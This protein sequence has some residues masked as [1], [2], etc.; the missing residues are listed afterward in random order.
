MRYCCFLIVP[1]LCAH[2]HPGEGRFIDSKPSGRDDYGPENEV[3]LN[4]FTTL[5]AN[6]SFILVFI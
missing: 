6:T 2:L 4:L 3:F 1:V 5:M